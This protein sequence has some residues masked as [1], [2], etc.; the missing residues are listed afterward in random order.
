M[1][2]SHTVLLFPALPDYD[3][4]HSI[5]DFDFGTQASTQS[6]QALQYPFP[7]CL[8]S[9]SRNPA[10]RI[11]PFVPVKFD[12][13]EQDLGNLAT[14]KIH[15]LL[16][17]SVSTG[18]RGDAACDHSHC[19]AMSVAICIRSCPFGISLA[20]KRPCSSIGVEFA[21][22]SIDG[23]FREPPGAK[24]I[25]HDPTHIRQTAV[26]TGRQVETMHAVSFS[27]SRNGR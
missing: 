10:I 6:F 3:M 18:T 8:W 19:Y 20:V 4:T 9:Q 21:R 23:A 2:V 5:P 13:I 25:G 27:K 15:S 11:A 26:V 14:M 16:D 12:R 24:R 7:G 1:R 22:S 17:R